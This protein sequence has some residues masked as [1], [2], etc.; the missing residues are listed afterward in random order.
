MAHAHFTTLVESRRIGE[1]C[2]LQT[3]RTRGATLERALQL[4][5]LPCVVRAFDLDRIDDVHH[6]GRV[7]LGGGRGEDIGEVVLAL[8]VVVAQVLQPAAQCLAVGDEDAGVDGADLAL[9]VVG[10]LVFDDAAHA[11]LRIAHDAAVAGGIVEI[12]DQYRDAAFCGEQT[13]QRLGSDERHVAVQHQHACIDRHRRHRVLHGMAGA[14]ALLLLGPVEIGLVGK[15]GTDLLAAVA[16]NDVDPCGA[17]LARGVD[18]VTQHRLAGDLLQHLGRGGLHA[19][20]LAG[21]E[22][23][24]V[25]RVHAMRDSWTRPRG[26]YQCETQRAV[27]VGRVQGARGPRLESRHA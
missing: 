24:D 15:R 19:L 25:E 1:S 7:E 16:V 8:R 12:G 10:V 18:H 20:A 17:E 26:S 14:Q 13:L 6:L 9:L 3:Q 4:R 23:D 21:G 22:D 2:T 11:A 27:R 5:E